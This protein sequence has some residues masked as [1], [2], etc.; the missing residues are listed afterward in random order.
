MNTWI[1][2]MDVSTLLAVEDHGGRF[3]DNGR[4]GDAMEIL[5][6]YGMNLVRLR[7]WNDPFDAEGNAYGA[8]DC[9]I[10]TVLALARRAKKLG[11]GW[12]LDFH[13]SDFWAD[14]GKQRVPKA[15]RGMNAKELEQAVYDFSVQVLAR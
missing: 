13:Y 7:L 5:S 9:D 12:L 10:D 6:D 1:T 15:W 2:G 3:Y 8:G 11:I 4:P 14:P